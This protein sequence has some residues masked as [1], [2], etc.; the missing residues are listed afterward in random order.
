ME[1]IFAW[2]LLSWKEI[3]IRTTFI[4]CKIFNASILFDFRKIRSMQ[5]LFLSSFSSC[6][7]AVRFICEEDSYRFIFGV[8]YEKW[9][10]SINKIRAAID[11]S[12][13]SMILG[14]LRKVLIKR[15]GFMKSFFIPSFRL[16]VQIILWKFSFL[17]FFEAFFLNPNFKQ[18]FQKIYFFRLQTSDQ[19]FLKNS[20]VY[21][22]I[23]FRWFK[24]KSFNFLSSYKNYIF[25][26]FFSFLTLC[27]LKKFFLSLIFSR[28]FIFFTG[29]KSFFLF[30]SFENNFSSFFL[31][32]FSLSKGCFLKIFYFYNFCFNLNLI[33]AHIN[34]IKFF[35]RSFNERS[36]VFLINFLNF[37]I[38]SWLAKAYF[39]CFSRSILI[40]L[41]FFL[42]RILWKWLRKRHYNKS[43]SWIFNNYWKF[44]KNRWVFFDLCSHF[45]NKKF[46]YKFFNYNSFD[47]YDLNCLKKHSFK[48]LR[49]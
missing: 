19:F 4:Q 40:F 1:N 41:D 39:F 16:R 22:R 5:R 31:E 33:K 43:S 10:F 9:F 3:E 30:N 12:L 14:I 37:L 34:E 27:R 13:N 6:L 44:S 7:I 15:G 36:R 48:I 18:S 29:F 32:E 28:R 47:F 26:D 38:K 21:K 35:F 24:C 46:I 8:D 25:C 2:D 42:Y 49:F 45:S 11:I 17:S 23:L 20:F